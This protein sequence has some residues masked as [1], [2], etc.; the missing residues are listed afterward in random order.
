MDEA[1]VSHC[2]DRSDKRD[3][4]VKDIRDVENYDAVWLNEFKF[5]FNNTNSFFCRFAS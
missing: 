4:G 1:T 3:V 5:S 2:N